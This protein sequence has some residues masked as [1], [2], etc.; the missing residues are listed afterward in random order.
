[1]LFLTYRGV[2]MFKNPKFQMALVLAAGVLAGYAA[3]SGKFSAFSGARAA[4]PY[5]APATDRTGGECPGCC[6]EE[7]SKPELLARASS[8]EKQN[9]AAES[10]EAIVFVVRLPAAAKL[11]VEGKMTT[12]TGGERQFETPPLPTG[13]QYSYNLTATLQDKTV[14]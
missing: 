10:E 12:S 5:A 2:G 9:G 14:K 13:K 1:P 3:A 4:P 11:E 6:G 8:E 7:V